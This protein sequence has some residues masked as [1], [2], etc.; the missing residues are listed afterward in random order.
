MRDDQ[1]VRHESVA[2]DI[3]HDRVG[4]RR[5]HDGSDC[6]PIKA[7]GQIDGI[8][9]PDNHHHRKGDIE[10]AKIRNEILKEWDTELGR[11]T[12]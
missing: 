11:I 7:I 5:D 10:P 3:R 12:R 6:E 2:G 4:H 9:T 1:I 8:G